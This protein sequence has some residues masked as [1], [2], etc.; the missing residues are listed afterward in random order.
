MIRKWKFIQREVLLE[1][2]RMM[3]VEDTVELSDGSEMTYLREAPTNDYSVAVMAF[4]ESGELLIQREFSYPPDEVLYQLPGGH[5]KQDE[6]IMEVANRELSEESGYAA[7]NC[8]V[9]GS[10]Y[11]NNRR[12]NRKQFVVVCEDLYQ[13]KLAQDK[14]EFIESEWVSMVRLTQLVKDGLIVNMNMLAALELYR[15]AKAI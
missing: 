12:S 6:D 11:V 13:E 7:R 1:H 4:N 14:E 2:P 10:F 15:A 9:I 3:I 5:S 8:R